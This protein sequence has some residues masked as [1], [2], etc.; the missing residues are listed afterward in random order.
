MNG[1]VF[2]TSLNNPII[3]VTALL[4]ASSVVAAA[5]TEPSRQV[6]LKITLSESE[7]RSVE[8]RVLA[9]PTIAVMLG[10]PFSFRSGG[11]LSSSSSNG[12][13]AI[14]IGTRVRGTVKK[15]DGD[16]LLVALQLAVGHAVMDA[17]DP[18]TTLAKT[19]TLDLRTSMI[20]GQEKEFYCGR[21]QVLKIHVQSIP[22]ADDEPS[23]ATKGRASR[24]G[25]GKSTTGPR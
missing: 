11:E 16:S 8:N 19:E 9:E 12:E 5:D 24:F 20:I 23:D 18:E 21:S 22:A 6:I 1:V 25:N 3:V 10:R 13:D 7:S 17:C 4:M 2:V 14:E 15:H